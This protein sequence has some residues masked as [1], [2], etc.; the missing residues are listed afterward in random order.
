M[1]QRFTER[2]RRSVFFAQ[3]EASRLHLAYVGTEHLLLGML[4]EEDALCCRILEGIGYPA[5]EI[6]EAL[7]PHLK[8][9]TDK[10]GIDMQLTPYCKRAIDLSYDEA[11]NLDNNYIGTEHILLGLIE[12]EN[13]LA[14]RTMR[15]LGVTPEALRESIRNLQS[16]DRSSVKPLENARRKFEQWMGAREAANPAPPT[17]EELPHPG[18]LGTLSCSRGRKKVEFLP[19]Q[20]DW[21]AYQKILRV[22]DDY[23]YREM[24]EAGKLLLVPV[25]TEAKFLRQE[26]A[27]FIRILSGELAGRTGWVLPANFQRTGQDERPFPP[28][29]E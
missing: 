17:E 16:F 12:E 2:A 21:V 13:G 11:R 6:R 24:I 27:F 25:E 9:G 28:E 3:Q 18:D 10:S 23:A 26:G 19:S 7:H 1:W 14:G 15:E 5:R 4:R 20:E 29:I 22:K 8:E